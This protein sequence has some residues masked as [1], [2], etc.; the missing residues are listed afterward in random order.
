[1]FGK[2]NYMAIFPL[3]FLVPYSQIEVNLQQLT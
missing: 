3:V 1:M 2:Q